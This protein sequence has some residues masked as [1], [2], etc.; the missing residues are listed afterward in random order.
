MYVCVV[1][2]KAEVRFHV[3]T[4]D[5]I[6]AEVRS[7]LL[8]R[9]SVCVCV[10]VCVCGWGWW[11]GGVCVFALCRACRLV[12][13]VCVCVGLFVGCVWVCVFVGVCVCVCGVTNPAPLI[14]T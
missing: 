14:F 6:P 4:A 10:C 11:C 13:H 9:V 7:E 3:Q 8:L 1:N 5:W 2:S 12:V